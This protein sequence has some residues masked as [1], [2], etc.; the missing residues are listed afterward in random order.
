MPQ[1]RAEHSVSVAQPM[2]TTYAELGERTSDRIGIAP[3]NPRPLSKRNNGHDSRTVVM[4]DAVARRDPAPERFGAVL[5]PMPSDQASGGTVSRAD[6]AALMRLVEGE[7]AER[8]QL[9]D[10]LATEQEANAQMRRLF[11]QFLTARERE[12]ECWQVQ[13]DE[14]RANL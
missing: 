14:T 1:E 7:Q 6:F 4:V 10:R 3:D 11:A 5:P 13:L 2:T 12:K 9:L 8:T